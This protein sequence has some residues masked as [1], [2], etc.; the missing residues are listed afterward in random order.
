MKRDTFTTPALAIQRRRI[1]S[2]AFRLVQPI[3]SRLKSVKSPRIEEDAAA[4]CIDDALQSATRRVFRLAPGK[5]R[6]QVQFRDPG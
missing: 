6:G 1:A 3:D 5:K 2:A 4:H